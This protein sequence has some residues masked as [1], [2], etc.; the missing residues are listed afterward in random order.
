MFQIF[1]RKHE[2]INRL[3]LFV[4]GFIKYLQ[5]YPFSLK[6]IK[7]NCHVSHKFIQLAYKYNYKTV[8]YISFL[9]LFNQVKN[10]EKTDK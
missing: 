8:T 1:V 9:Y 7:Y 6:T 2:L 3:L 4:R 10:E 5:K